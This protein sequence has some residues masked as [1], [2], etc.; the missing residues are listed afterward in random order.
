M[1]TDNFKMIEHKNLVISVS[2]AVVIL[3]GLS[4][5]GKVSRRKKIMN[6]ES[7]RKTYSK[8]KKSTN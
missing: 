4:C 1:T 3:I 6:S 8:F 2:V 7:K 5:G